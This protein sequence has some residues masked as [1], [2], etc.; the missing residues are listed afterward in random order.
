M[1]IAIR[2][3]TVLLALSAASF[4]G[5]TINSP[6]NG[7][8]SNSPVHV[9]ASATPNYS[10]TSIKAMQ[11]YIDGGLVYSQPGSAVNAYFKMG[12]GWHSVTVKAW[13]S[14]GNSFMS[15]R[16]VQGS[17]SGIFLNSPAENTS[18][19]SVRVQGSSY[20]PYGIAAMA[21]Y[22]NSN[23]VTKV[24]G[25]YLDTTVNLSSGSHYLMIQAWDNKGNIFFNPVKVYNGGSTSSSGSTGSSSQVA[26]P[27]YATKKLDIDQMTGW[28]HCDSCAGINGSG[29]STPY[30]MT[31]FISS[32]SIDGKSAT[33]WLGG[34]TPYS[35]ALWWKQLG[36]IDT[37]KNFVYDLKFYIPNPSAAQA[38]EFDMNQSVGGYK[39]IFGTECGIFSGNGWRIWDTANVR[40]VSTGKACNVKAGAWNHL[41]WEFQ[42]VGT[43]T[44]FIAVTL[45]GNRQVIDKYFWARPVSARE[46][47][48]AF[49]MDGN[50]QQTDYQVWL[51]Q[52][53]LYVW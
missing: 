12:Q 43:Q 44:R 39:Y 6:A 46:L 33:F 8:T 7:A 42:R 49:Q 23:L 34:T 21:I 45:N 27:S 25:S 51:D 9:S 53:N 20:S 17:G 15:S 11:V 18:A 40:W 47:N 52:V 41:T 26:I 24:G 37:A 28:D 31:Q 36:A 29:P 19:S 38:L 5:V 22:D 16:S 2:L 1:K 10:N 13:D 4:A 50:Y 48:V 14:A 35:N 30:S 3:A 32:P